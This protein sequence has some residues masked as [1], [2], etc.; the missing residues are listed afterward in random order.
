MLSP[1]E[2]HIHLQ[3]E[4]TLPFSLC[5]HYRMG[6]TLTG[7]QALTPFWKGSNAQG[8]KQELK[9]FPFVKMAE[10][11]VIIYFNPTALRT[12]KTLWSFGRSE[13]N[14][15]KHT[16]PLFLNFTIKQCDG[17]FKQNG[18]E[19]RALPDCFQS[20]DHGPHC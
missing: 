10:K 8:S 4:A 12:A 13:C 2:E 19:Y 20:S 9:L 1:S 11:L 5:F 15:V 17:Y 6:S 3:R 16:L 18:E 7:N 14:R